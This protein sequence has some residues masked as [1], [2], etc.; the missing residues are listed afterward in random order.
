MVSTMKEWS[1]GKLSATKVFTGQG[2]E[3]DAKGTAKR[4]NEVNPDV[5]A[6]VFKRLVR[7]G[8][9]TVE[10]WVLVVRIKESHANQPQ[11]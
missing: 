7:A 8:R 11:T 2:A 4:V 6:R 10:V 9:A 3:E 5:G 1:A